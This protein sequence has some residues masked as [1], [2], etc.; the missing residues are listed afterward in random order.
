LAHCINIAK[1]K[2]VIYSPTFS[3]MFLI[4]RKEKK[5]PTGT[6]MSL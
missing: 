6:E 4:K 1:A 3:D 2:A 5:H